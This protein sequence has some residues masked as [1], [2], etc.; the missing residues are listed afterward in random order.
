MRFGRSGHG[1]RVSPSSGLRRMSAVVRVAGGGG[2]PLSPSDRLA[3]V[4]GDGRDERV[5]RL[6]W[7]LPAEPAPDGRAGTP[8]S[9]GCIPS[10]AAVRSRVTCGIWVEHQR[11][12]VSPCGIAAIASGSIGATAI[13]KVR[14][15]LVD[16]HRRARSVVN[17][18]RPV[19]GP[20]SSSLGCLA[21]TAVDGV[22]VVDSTADLLVGKCDR[23]HRLPK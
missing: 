20:G 1:R 19:S 21:P 23:R 7:R 8:Q 11:V 4:T 6:G 9:S 10:D 15:A 2:S 14:D 13:R 12:S 16:A 5:V 17:L 3:E 22:R 18:S